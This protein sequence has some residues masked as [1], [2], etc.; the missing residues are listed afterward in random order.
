MPRVNLRVVLDVAFARSHFPALETDWALMDNAGGSVVARSVIDRVRGY[1]SRYCVQLGASYPLST[2]AAEL[3][4]AGKRAAEALVN[5]DEGEVFLGPSTTLNTV[6]LSRA[7]AA[8]MRRGDTII[9]TNLDHES[10]VGPWRALETQGIRIREWKLNPDTV[11]LEAEDLAKLLDDSVRLVALCHV[12]NVVGAIHDIPE[13]C[14][15][16]HAA[17]AQVMV[18]GVAFAPHRRVDVK[19]LDVDYYAMSLYKVYGPHIG[20]VYGKAPLLRRAAGQNHFF[21]GEDVV[22]YKFEPGN[23]CH[24]LCASLPGVLEY[25]DALDEHHFAGAP[26]DQATR[27]GRVFGLIAQHEQSLAEPLLAFLDGRAGARII[28]P[29]SGHLA[30]RVPTIAF[31]VEGMRSDEVVARLDEERVATRFGHFYAYRP[32]RRLGLLEHEGVVRVSMVHY[33]RP[34]EVQRLVSALDRILPN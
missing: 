34:E 27:L 1:M 32:I 33:N 15:R 12:S 16:A 3:V 25:L 24:E 4:A 23:V 6:L 21:V 17:G 7:L 5:A 26:A 18:D 8:N 9:V 30:V 29:S 11:T 10:N 31:T 20:L 13:I 2:E 19:A 22:P 28:G 14:R